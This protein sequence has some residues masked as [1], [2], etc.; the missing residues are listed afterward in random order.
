MI[1]KH[2]F[3]R[4]VQT[5][6]QLTLCVRIPI[7]TMECYMEDWKGFI[8]TAAIISLIPKHNRRVRGFRRYFFFDNFSRIPR[9][10]IYSSHM[11]VF[12]PLPFSLAQWLNL[13]I[14]QFAILPIQR[15]TSIVLGDRHRLKVSG[16]R[17]GFPLFFCGW[18]EKKR[19]FIVIVNCCS[20]H[21]EGFKL[22][23]S[24]NFSIVII[25]CYSWCSS[26]CLALDN[27]I[28]NS[29]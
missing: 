17:L 7:F 2:I 1:Y 14:F 13:A 16:H 27:L 12:P 22:F 10:D 23:H 20:P 9:L 28:H 18:W 6:A 15:A 5:P 29:Q 8:F 21:G 25:V 11:R 24:T 26:T 3:P 4:I 19:K